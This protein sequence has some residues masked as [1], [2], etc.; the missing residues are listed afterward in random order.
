MSEKAKNKPEISID[1][2]LKGIE[3]LEACL[4]HPKQ[5]TPDLKVFHFDMKLEHKLNVENKFIAVVFYV[6]LFNAERDIKLGSVTASCIFEIANIDD[7]LDS[8]TQNVNLPEDFLIS[9]NS[10]TI[11]TVRGIMF[12]QFKGTFL[13]N[14]FLPIID[15]KS[16]TVQ[17]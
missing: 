5:A 1:V 11:S 15:P 3:L 4:N 6:D 8:K 7:F 14:A 17:K 12:S 2:Q 13:H 9:I 10:I 16:F